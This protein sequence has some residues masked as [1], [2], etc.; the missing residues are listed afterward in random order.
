MAPDSTKTQE[1]RP[2]T[3]EEWHAN[4]LREHE[5][6]MR[7]VDEALREVREEHRP[8]ESEQPAGV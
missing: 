7:R 4:F 3:P 2:L 6:R 5:E 8:V 1:D